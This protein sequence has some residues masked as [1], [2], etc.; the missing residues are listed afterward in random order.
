MIPSRFKKVNKLTRLTVQL[1]YPSTTSYQKIPGARCCDN[2]EP[3]KFP[4]E[5]IILQKDPGLKRGKKRKVPENQMSVMRDTLKEWHE[6]EL[7]EHVYP[8]LSTIS[9]RT[10]LGDDIVEKIVNCCERLTTYKE[11][12]RHARWVLGHDAETDGPSE[13]G[14]MLLAVLHKVYQQFDDEAEQAAAE[15]QRTR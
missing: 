3:E 12:R 15:L 9:G 5:K 2:C 8:G 10:I 11:L 6:N 7:L 4:I 14:T 13:I 1:A